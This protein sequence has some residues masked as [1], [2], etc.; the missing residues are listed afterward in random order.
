MISL[1]QILLLQEKVENAVSKIEQ[2]NAE[3]AALRRKCA[4][5]TNVLAA[6][7]EQFSSF[8]NNQNK[9]E[10]GILAALHKLDAVE[11]KVLESSAASSSS[12]NSEEV[13]NPKPEES[14][15]IEQTSDNQNI[16]SQVESSS[17]PEI[18]SENLQEPQPENQWPVIDG[19]QSAQTDSTNANSADQSIDNSLSFENSEKTAEDSSSQPLFDIF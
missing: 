2:L 13:Q 7:T 5:L 16:Q 1:E 3:N 18:V 14:T 11:S 19:N 9:I 12:E 8:Q 17:E 6:K 10:E 15:Q 4:E